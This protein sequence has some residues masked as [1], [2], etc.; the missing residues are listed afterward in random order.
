MSKSMDFLVVHT[1]CSVQRCQKVIEV[2]GQR[3]KKNIAS[4]Y[5]QVTN[6][7]TVFGALTVAM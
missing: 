1:L 6:Q 5:K 7:H 3:K 2:A 4:C